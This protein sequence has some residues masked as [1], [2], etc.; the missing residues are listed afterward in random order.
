MPHGQTGAR[1]HLLRCCH[2][3]SPFSPAPCAAEPPVVGYRRRRPLR[4]ASGGRTSQAHLALPP[5]C[6]VTAA[7]AAPVCGGGEEPCTTRELRA[8]NTFD[9]RMQTT[10]TP[11]VSDART[12]SR[13][14]SGWA[15]PRCPH[16][17]ARPGRTPGL[18]CFLP[19]LGDVGET[20]LL[21]LLLLRLRA[22]LFNIALTWRPVGDRARVAVRF[23]VGSRQT[24]VSARRLGSGMR[25]LRE[26]L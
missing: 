4:G 9:A 8:K 5:W 14:R 17:R 20:G 2:L 15:S 6:A 10:T 18:A 3:I 1:A 12:C 23:C 21:Q 24:L 13:R 25:K 26:A 22:L 19:G 7:A 16:P 11:S